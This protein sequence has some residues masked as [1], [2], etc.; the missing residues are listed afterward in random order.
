M[1]LVAL[2]V[3]SV[4]VLIAEVAIGSLGRG[5]P[6]LALHWAASVGNL[7]SRWRFL[8]VAQALLGL[9]FAAVAI[10]TAVWCL[11]CVSVLYSGQLASASAID[12]ASR[13]FGFCGR[14]S[15]TV[16]AD[17]LVAGGGGKRLGARYPIWDGIFGVGVST[18]GS[19]YAFG[20]Y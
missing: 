11:H 10:L 2:C 15:C 17:P 4:P 18:G 5:S 12:V 3:L 20:A 8:G 7:D 13:L 16:H 19:D 1:Y 6:G 9:V 14:S